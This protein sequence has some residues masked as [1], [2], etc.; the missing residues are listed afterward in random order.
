MSKAAVTPTQYS[1]WRGAFQMINP[2]LVI[3]VSVLH[4]RHIYSLIGAAIHTITPVRWENAV[5]Y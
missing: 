5:S 4:L 1:G 2:I 3:I